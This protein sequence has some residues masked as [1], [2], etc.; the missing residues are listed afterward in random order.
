[1]P[2]IHLPLQSGNND[3]LKI[4]GRRYTKEEYLA[5]FNKLKTRIPEIALSTDI[6]VGFPN[7][8]EAQFQETLE[9][10]DTCQFDNVYSFIY[11]PRDKT[12]AAAMI[13]NVTKAEKEDRL[14]RLNNRIGVHALMHNQ[15]QVGKTLA[16]L[17]DGP[18]KKNPDIYSGY[19]ET[20]K[21]VN[22]KPLS[23]CVG[24]IVQVEITSA[25]TWTLQGKQVS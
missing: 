3:I 17:V 9:M 16:V 8:T 19:T 6:I 4:M 24:E 7:E 18:S 21:L 5:I 20:N 1:M 15:A 23:D 13:D 2:F 14:Q 22:F 12:P 25:K 10:I 11:S